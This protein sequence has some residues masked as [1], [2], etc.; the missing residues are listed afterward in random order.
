MTRRYCIRRTYRDRDGI[1]RTETRWKRDGQSF[2][3]FYGLAISL[4]AKRD[5][6]TVSLY[7]AT[8]RYRE[9]RISLPP[10][11]AQEFQGRLF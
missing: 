1:L 4:L 8:V 2:S 7:E 5:T 6:E 11:K 3:S 10:E 9:V